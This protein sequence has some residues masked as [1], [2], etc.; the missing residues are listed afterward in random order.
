MAGSLIGLF[1]SPIGLIFLL[2]DLILIGFIL[3]GLI[4]IGLILIGLIFDWESPLTPLVASVRT[5]VHTTKVPQ[6]A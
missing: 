5:I 3:I 1:F 4:L 6:V 2:I